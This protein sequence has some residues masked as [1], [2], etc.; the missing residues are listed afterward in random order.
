MRARTAVA[1]AAALLLLL[2]YAGRAAA[3]CPENQYYLTAGGFNDCDYCAE[4][5]YTLD[6]NTVS[7]PDN[8]VC[9]PCPLGTYGTMNG[10]GC[11]NVCEQGQRGLIIGATSSGSCAACATGYSTPPEGSGVCNE[12]WCAPAY[13]NTGG[14]TCWPCDPGSVAPG[15]S[16]D[17]NR[18]YQCPQ[19]SYADAPQTSCVGCGGGTSTTAAGQ[20]S[21]DACQQ[22]YC[23]AGYSKNS[24]LTTCSACAI[25]TYA[26]GVSNTENR[27]QACAVGTYRATTAGTAC[28]SCG[29]GYTTASTGATAASDCVAGSGTT[30]PAGQRVT[31]DA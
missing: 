20:T 15:H 5:T 25:G 14:T 1:A 3:T 6:G 4:G 9:T 21:I 19:G 7:G 23:A 12:G 17:A 29:A 2:L 24:G 27:C 26:A 22:G 28:T 8:T 30:C 13:T 10:A 31:M 16:D 11:N 18:C